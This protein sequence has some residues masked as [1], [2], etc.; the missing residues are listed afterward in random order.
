[1]GISET[2]SVCGGAF[3]VQFRYQMEERD[4]GFS[5]YCSQKCLEKS[6]VTGADQGG[7]AAVTCDAC[8][9]RFQPDLVSQVLYLAGRRR[10][11]CSMGC[12]T[13]LLREANGVRLGEIAAQ[14]SVAPPVSSKRGEDAPVSSKARSARGSADGQVR[15]AAAAKPQVQASMQAPAAVAVPVVPQTKRPGA[16]LQDAKG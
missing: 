14:A 2:C 10:Y 6:Q 3:D 16:A 11:A 9:K 1:M 7:S 13:Q 12:R 8:A 5:F 4:G 15:V